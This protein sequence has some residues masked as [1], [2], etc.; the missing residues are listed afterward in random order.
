LISKH[1]HQL[2]ANPRDM[3]CDMKKPGCLSAGLSGFQYP[4]TVR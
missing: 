1:F 2:P 3:E 4:V